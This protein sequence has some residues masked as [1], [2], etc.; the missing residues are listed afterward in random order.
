MGFMNKSWKL[1]SSIPANQI[2]FFSRYFPLKE[3]K[4]R[5]WWFEIAIVQWVDIK[6]IWDEQ[7]WLV[8]ESRVGAEGG[9]SRKGCQHRGNS[10]NEM[11]SLVGKI[12]NELMRW[13]IQRVGHMVSTDGWEGRPGQ[14]L[15]HGGQLLSTAGA[16]SGSIGEFFTRLTECPRAEFSFCP[17]R[18]FCYGLSGHGSAFDL[19][20]PSP[21]AS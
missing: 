4:R 9:K 7:L 10:H 19:H 11:E 15:M 6:D 3:Q 8:N 1:H 21:H 5:R 18:S 14:Q 12:Q 17:F 16:E 2:R 13:V 20:S